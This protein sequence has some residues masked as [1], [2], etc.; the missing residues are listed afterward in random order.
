MGVEGSGYS[1][2][3]FH[4][5]DTF[6]RIFRKL[7]EWNISIIVD[8]DVWMLKC[9]NDVKWLFIVIVFVVVKCLYFPRDRGDIM[10]STQVE[11]S[12]RLSPGHGCGHS[13]NIQNRLFDSMIA[14]ARWWLRL[15]TNNVRELNICLVHSSEFYHQCAII[16]LNVHVSDAHSK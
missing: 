16:H 13:H 6:R 12:P 4:P 9:L 3:V 8:D 15:C 14:T 7:M 2:R 1:V 5:I 11:S 10:Y